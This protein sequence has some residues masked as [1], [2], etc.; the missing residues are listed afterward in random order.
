METSEAEK[1]E[2]GAEE[3]AE[4]GEGKVFS[5][6]PKAMIIEQHIFHMLTKAN[7]N[8]TTSFDVLAT[9]LSSQRHL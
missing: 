9:I 6:I 8:A 7:V 1:E 4:G 3:E 5:H 2:A